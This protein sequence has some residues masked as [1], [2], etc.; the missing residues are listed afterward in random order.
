MYMY[1][2]FFLWD[3][4]LNLYNN[5]MWGVGWGGGCLGFGAKHPHPG[6]LKQRGR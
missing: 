6:V 1:V 5:K 4:E 3:K 2:S